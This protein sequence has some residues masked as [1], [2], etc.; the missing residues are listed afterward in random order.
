[1]QGQSEGRPGSAGLAHSYSPRVEA[2]RTDGPPPVSACPLGVI[3][4]VGLGSM[5]VG[6]HRNSL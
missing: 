5:L 1:M 3:V 2:P 6:S 4:Q